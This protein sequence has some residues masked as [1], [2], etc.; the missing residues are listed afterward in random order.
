MQITP[1]LPLAGA[2]IMLENLSIALADDNNDVCVVSLYN[3]KSAIT[4]RLEEKKIPIV[5]LNKKK[6]F[7]I[8]MVFRLYKLFTSYRPEVVHT[9]RY[10]M[11]YVIPAA[12]LSGVPVRVHTV[13]NIAE[14]ELGKIQRKINSVFYRFFRVTPIAISPIIKK[15]IMEEY[16]LPKDRIPMIY[17][18]LNLE[19][20]LPKIEYTAKNNSINILH[21]GRF[22]K[23]K[24]HIGLIESFKIVHDR[25]PKAVLTL[26]GTGDLENEI[27][28][29]VKELN[30]EKSVI[31]AGVQSE[32]YK[33]Y[34]QADIFVLPS[35]WEGMPIT[36][37]E[38]MA[39][40]V[41]I[42]ATKVGGIP[43]MVEHKQTALLV[44]I[45]ENKIAQAILDLIENNELREKIGQ[46]AKKKAVEFSSRIMKE[47]YLKVYR[48]S[49]K[50]LKNK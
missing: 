12:I 26:V 30:L 50:I 16:K 41:P 4:E 47:E 11:Q 1:N 7:D 39:S 44:D 40:G 8:R 23:Q 5:Y 2:E 20:Y 6:G 25:E 17:N 33:F 43:D 18:G 21:I 22:E 45:D 29:L 24:N 3:Q 15:T 19:K 46:N 35:L 48:N 32:V 36:L 13:H 10:V 38:A 31:F 27:F 9:H 49:S 42:V 14:K 37:I 34:N 28:G